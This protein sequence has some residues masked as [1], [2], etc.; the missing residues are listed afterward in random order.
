MYMSPAAVSQCATILGRLPA[1][2]ELTI[3]MSQSCKTDPSGFLQ[4]LT[5][6]TSLNLQTHTSERVLSMCTAAARNP[7]L[8]V[9][10]VGSQGASRLTAAELQHLLASCPSLTTLDMPFLPVSDDVL[11]V[12]LTHGKKITTLVAA[13]FR[14]DGSFADRQ[15]SWKRVWFSQVDYPY[16]PVLLLLANAP[17]KG[18]EELHGGFSD[19]GILKLPL[20]TFAP[21]QVADLL[22]RATTNIA[23]C[24]QWQLAPGS[25]I[26]L[27][28]DP[29]DSPP[30]DVIF[31][32]AQRIQLLEAL[33]PLGGPHVKEF[34]AAIYDT[35]FEWGE[36][37]LQALG[38]SLNSERLSALQLSYCI[39]TSGFWAALDEV[40]PSLSDLYLNGDVT[41]S[42][43]ALFCS[44][45]GQG[46][47]LS[48]H[49]QEDLYQSSNGAQLQA[50][51]EQHSVANVKVLK[52]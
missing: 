8:Q 7:A 12:L 28:H 5:C 4:Q 47:M 21:D 29:E 23:A 17:L 11:E 15:C 25:F 16:Y 34:N 36:A 51:L 3:H 37:E 26:S 24:R 18:V 42:D 50:S 13:S 1:L 52:W 9:L 40:L 20:L 49:L 35:D 22:R 10:T 45:R 2:R 39:V 43:L 27:G 38:R 46:H 19:L 41:G 44:K 31:T 33:A 6:L 30:Q 48:I 14:T 32:P